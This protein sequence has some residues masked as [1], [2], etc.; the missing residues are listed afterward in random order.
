M[1][2]SFKILWNK[3]RGLLVV[4]DEHHRAM[5][6][7][8]VRASVWATPKL[9]LAAL[10]S[11]LVLLGLGSTPLGATTITVP[12]TSTDPTVQSTGSVHTIT[13]GVVEN[14]VA[15]NRFKQFN[16]SAG[17]IANMKFGK[18]STWANTLVNLVKEGKIEVHGVLNAITKTNG[19]EGIGGNLVFITPTGLVVGTSGVINAGSFTALVVNPNAFERDLWNKDP[20]WLTRRWSEDWQEKVNT[21]EVPINPN[22][23][24][25]VNGKINTNGAMLLAAGKIELGAEGTGASLTSGVTNF[26]DLVNVKSG[27]VTTLNSGISNLT[28]TKAADGSIE[29]IAR[30][31]GT[32]TGEHTSTL[33]TWSSIASSKKEFDPLT[34]AMKDGTKVGSE[35]INTPTAQ[36]VIKAGSSVLAQNKVTIEAAA[37]AGEYQVKSR[38]SATGTR[39]KTT[40]DMQSSQVLA[41]VII[42]G[43]MEG[44]SVKA[45]ALAQND[46]DHSLGFN[47]NTLTTVYGGVTP[48]NGSRV[49]FA[50]LTT[51]ATLAVNSTGTVV[52]KTGDVDLVALSQTSINVNQRSALSR[53][54]NHGAMDKMPTVA[55]VVSKMD[56]S[57]TTTVAGTIDSATSVK[58]HSENTS[59]LDV[60]ATASTRNTESSQAAIV[61]ADVKGKASTNVSGT[62][63][64]TNTTA[65]ANLT[66]VA[67]TSKQESDVRTAVEATSSEGAHAALA[68]NVTRFK[69]GS[70][71]T[72][73]GTL[74]N[75]PA[76][77][78]IASDNI[79]KTLRVKAKSSTGDDG[80]ISNYLADFDRKLFDNNGAGSKL[81]DAFGGSAAEGANKTNTFQAGGAFGYIENAQLS[82]VTVSSD[83]TATNK[84]TVRSESELTDH[85]YVVQ[86]KHEIKEDSKVKNSAALSILINRPGSFTNG[87]VGAH[88]TVASGVTLTAPTLELINRAA[89]SKDRWAAYKGDWVAWWDDVKTIFTKAGY[90]DKVA[91]LQTS[92]DTFVGTLNENDTEG[93]LQGS[94]DQA[95]QQF[96]SFTAFGYVVKDAFSVV[97]ET[98]AL[99]GLT[100]SAIFRMADFLNPCT[101]AN[102]CVTAGGTSRDAQTEPTVLNGAIAY[103]EQTVKGKLIVGSNS[104]LQTT[105]LAGGSVTVNGSTLN[106]HIVLGHNRNT[107]FGV[108]IGIPFKIG[109]KDIGAVEGM[110]G[111]AV[112]GSVLVEAL[113]TD[114]LVQILEKAQLS[115][116]LG[117][118]NVNAS[119]KL[120]AYNMALTAGGGEGKLSLIGMADATILDARN[121]LQIDDE[122]HLKAKD[123]SAVASRDD[124][125]LGV[126]G[127]VMWGHREFLG[128]H[129]CGRQCHCGRCGQFGRSQRFRNDG[130]GFTDRRRR[131]DGE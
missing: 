48:L 35:H 105:G 8:K 61:Y 33:E 130:H 49:E 4:T 114:N 104:T 77:L 63:Q 73:S 69:T 120:Q 3:A 82:E 41:D 25:T 26:A 19:A 95:S 38:K 126:A 1:N 53:L 80:L 118:L 74:A 32:L 99:A 75:N 112:G 34:G 107:F 71:T 60:T 67:I 30:A 70:D 108:P 122:A 113:G 2:K 52:S 85:N 36:V 45:K 131:L 81:A 43:H 13:P 22:G 129:W 39:F 12:G 94:L 106:E 7:G 15:L 20:K 116:E 21:A 37:G 89:A 111:N 62:I 84:M 56:G 28:M 64:H 50:N 124:F 66:D 86:S 88:L 93:V 98:G 59:N 29:L 14:N 110:T 10:G 9:G 83:L 79:T 5:G 27:A 115:A 87:S 55:S 117:T 125:V 101:F 23:V 121:V 51:N 128:S 31:D 47:L 46:L 127:E 16:L 72:M 103:T 54:V 96:E 123:I 24:I 102:V 11:S 109:G 92:W 91:E 42:N 100:V 76:T 58:V 68:V 18:D 40:D 57:A 90:A 65:G 119:D 17:H 6:K 97:G 78:T 44:E